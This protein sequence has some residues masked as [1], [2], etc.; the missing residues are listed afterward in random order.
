MRHGKVPIEEEAP[1]SQPVLLRRGPVSLDLIHREIEIDGLRL[2]RLA[3]RRF[4]LLLALFRHQKPMDQASLLL[5][6]WGMERD[7]KVVQMTVARLREDLRSF[8]AIQIRTTAH[9]YELIIT[10]DPACL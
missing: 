3:S 4:D 7:L 10:P 2:P 1:L 8:P 5:E 9:C 6:V